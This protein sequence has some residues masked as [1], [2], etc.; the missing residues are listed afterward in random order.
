[1]GRRFVALFA[2]APLVFFGVV[3]GVALAFRVGVGLAREAMAPPEV[4][5]AFV[6]GP[7]PGL[8]SMGAKADPSTSTS[9]TPST[10][11]TPDAE[12]GA[13]A[14]VQPLGAPTAGLHA[15]PPPVRI[16]PRPRGHGRRPIRGAR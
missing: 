4:A 1:M 8:P 12:V 16:A 11:S 7:E 3:I 2:G 6:A 14:R 5:P 9:S 15:R 13:A 10:P